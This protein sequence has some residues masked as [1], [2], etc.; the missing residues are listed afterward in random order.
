MTLPPV[1]TGPAPPLMLIALRE[2]AAADPID[3]QT[4]DGRAAAGDVEAWRAPSVAV[5]LDDRRPGPSRLRRPV[6]DDWLG[7]RRQIR[8]QRDRLNAGS[9]DEERDR[10]G[11]ARVRV[12]VEDRLPQRSGARYRSCW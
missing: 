10:I 8:L 12:G 4:A 2:R 9:G 11:R 6:D 1:N 3:R 5:D 7:D